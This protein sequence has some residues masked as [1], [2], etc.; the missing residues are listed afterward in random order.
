MGDEENEMNRMSEMSECY[1]R[2][3]AIVSRVKTPDTISLHPS[4][5]NSDLSLVIRLFNSV[6][7]MYNL[8]FATIN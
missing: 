3:G 6:F 1:L 8:P 4:S 5:L 2:K 7:V